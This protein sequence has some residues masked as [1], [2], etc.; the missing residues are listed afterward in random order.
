MACGGQRDRGGAV[1]GGRR[2][3]I[4]YSFDVGVALDAKAAVIRRDLEAGLADRQVA[5]TITT[6][7]V[8]A[9]ALTVTPRDPATKPAIAEL[10]AQS[11]GETLAPRDCAPVAERDSICFAMAP[12]YAA[13]V[14]AS[15]WA[16]TV[17][18]VRRRLVAAKIPGATVVAQA[19]GIVVELPLDER[20][21]AGWQELV[22]RAG[23]LELVVADDG[24]APM[25][26]LA[27]HVA[28]DPR[29]HDA[30]ITVEV[31]Q[32]QGT[33]VGPAHMEPYLRAYDRE[34]DLPIER[35]RALGCF[36]RGADQGQVRC[37]VTGRQGILDYVGA[38]AV[39]DPALGLPADR[40]LGFERVEP[41]PTA[42]AARP[43]WRTYYLERDPALTG[44]SIARVESAR[45]PATH[46]PVVNLELDRD[47]TR[48]LAA[49]S[50]R[51]LGRKLATIVDGRIVRAPI[52]AGPL[53]G[54]R[55][56]IVVTGTDPARAADD[57]A[58][59]AR[60]LEGGALPAALR[61]ESV[62]E[63]P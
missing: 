46:Q 60:V 51:A 49:V 50:E 7:D 11:Y 14:E 1:G 38:L 30:G 63:L 3:Q 55:T 31:D 48:A 18:T 5:A 56:T 39:T 26:R 13:T 22:A 20:R 34:V 36:V 19:G 23:A 9:G 17:E 45:D 2:V 40:R 41:D 58:Q 61:E 32:W 16:Q 10:V 29:A 52:I 27:A 43:Y 54:G 15:A 33:G 6:P 37:M 24:A 25:A 53:P 42:A 35:A 21:L 8:A 44:A 47:G 4:T 28:D 59:L 57:A 12:A 62:R